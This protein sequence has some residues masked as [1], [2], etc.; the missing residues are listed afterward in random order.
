MQSRYPDIDVREAVLVE[1][2]AGVVTGGGVSLCIDT[3]LHLLAEMLGQH[4]AD[5]TA[6]IIEYQRALRANREGFLPLA[7]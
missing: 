7:R 1:Q 6:R 5:E 4:V 3:T 2:E